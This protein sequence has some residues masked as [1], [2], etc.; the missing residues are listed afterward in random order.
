MTSLLHI[1]LQINQSDLNNFYIDVLGGKL[2]NTFTLSSTD[3]QLI[4]GLNEEITAYFVSCEG[5]MFELFVRNK[6]L[7]KSCSHSCLLLKNATLIANRAKQK[8]YSLYVRKKYEKDT[9]FIK[10]LNNNLFEIKIQ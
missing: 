9:Y 7:E 1:G 3:A 2:E 10:D 5:I 4:F 8:G 6:S